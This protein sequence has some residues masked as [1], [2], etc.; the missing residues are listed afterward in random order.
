MREASITWVPI[1]FSKNLG[2]TLMGLAVSGLAIGVGV[3]LEALVS[4][5]A[6]GDIA[7]ALFLLLERCENGEE[8]TNRKQNI[9]LLPLVA[10]LLSSIVMAR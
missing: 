4:W 6:S 5:V 10:I 8:P 1:P 7:I 2:L 3:V 9:L